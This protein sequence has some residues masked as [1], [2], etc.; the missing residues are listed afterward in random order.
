VPNSTGTVLALNADQ[1]NLF[2]QILYAGDNGAPG[3]NA[4]T[5]DAFPIGIVG[6]GYRFGSTDNPFM[7]NITTSINDDWMQTW[8]ASPT[9]SAEV[10]VIQF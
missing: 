10:D 5:Y 6:A 9:H 8:G 2:L 4:G 3:N 1:F 7:F